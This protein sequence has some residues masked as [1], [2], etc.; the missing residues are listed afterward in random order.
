MRYCGLL[1]GGWVGGREGLPGTEVEGVNS[2]I[3][4]LLRRASLPLGD[5]FSQGGRWVGGWVGG[6][7]GLPR[8]QVEGIDSRV[9]LLF[10]R[11]SLPLSDDFG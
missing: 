7:V 6:W 2:C 4:L 5:N 11:A 1:V 3:E 10:R 9:Q 8:A